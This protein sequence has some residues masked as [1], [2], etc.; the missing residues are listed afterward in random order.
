MA[1]LRL[2]IS[3]VTSGN[4]ETRLFKYDFHSFRY[5]KMGKLEQHSARINRFWTRVHILFGP[6]IITMRPQNWPF[7]VERWLFRSREPGIQEFECWFAVLPN[8]PLVCQWIRGFLEAFMLRFQLSKQGILKLGFPRLKHLFQNSK[9]AISLDL[10]GWYSMSFRIQLAV[11]M[12]V[13][14]WL[15]TCARFR[16]KLKKSKW[17]ENAN[18]AREK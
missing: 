6:A 7:D 8:L 16:D 1:F 10:Y 15:I 17:K 3:A 18:R 5:Q 14:T 2:I 11:M 13:L 12:A 9:I 4:H